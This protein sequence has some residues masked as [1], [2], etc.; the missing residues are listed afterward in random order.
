MRGIVVTL[1]LMTLSAAAHAQ[2]ALSIAEVRTD[3]ATL[4][5][6]GIQVLIAGDAN[7]NAEIRVRYRPAGT[8]EYREALPLFRVLPETVTGRTVP[9]QL[10]GTIFD[11]APGGSYEIEL[12]AIDPDGGGETRMITGTTRAWPVDP[13][14]PHLV[15]VTSAGE[16]TAALQGAQPGDVIEL[17]DGTYAG[18]F[19]IN[20]SG[21]AEQPIVIRG[22][23]RD[24]TILDGQDCGGCNILEV[25]GS[26]V[27]VERLTI[28]HGVRA[29][30]FL[31]TGTTA[32]AAL[33]LR[34]E[35]VVHGIGAGTDQTD[36]TLCDNIVHG[37]LQW[38]LVYSDD[39]AVHADDQGIRVDGSGHV[40]C[41]N[42]IAGFGDP[43]INFAEGGRAYDF[44]GNDIHEIYADGTE[45]D[46]GEGNVRLW[47][48]RWTNVYTAISIQPAYGGPLYVLR[49]EVLNVADEQIKLKSV[50]GTVEPSGVLVY[51]NTFVSPDIALNLQTPITQHN[52]VIAN[53]LFVGPAQPA[54][55][56]V[57]WT[58]AIDRGVF[59]GN[60]YFPDSGYWFGTVGSARTFATLAEAQAA[61]IE[62]QGRVL[63][64]PIFEGGITAPGSYTS[65]LAPA[66]LVLAASSNAIDAGITLPGINSRHIGAG[67]DLGARELGCPAPQYG[68]RPAGSELVTNLVD[69]SAD[70]MPPGGD[71]GTDKPPGDDDAGGGGGC[72]QAPRDARGT[73]VV[74][75]ACVLGLQRRRRAAR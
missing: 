47:G 39:G 23:S 63:T 7:R 25:Y 72:C 71:A 2:N 28:A 17:A 12:E 9:E 50:G 48:N 75:I 40:V 13:A 26:Y 35:D 6:I 65:V 73:L 53:N 62:T 51:H 3:R 18:A 60:G 52:F 44:Y 29:L 11:V 22:A 69:C 27:H 38:P 34:I 70:A 37:R 14:T 8:Q 1:A 59:D 16:L 55:R 61:G 67:P 24:G 21:T 68:P 19:A 42:D 54:G 41:H 49:N 32:N 46:R 57:E 30:R 56:T 33:D 43:M 66:A 45:L 36:F 4:H 5:T 15:S 58:A 64:T 20:A 74:A 10:A 31:G